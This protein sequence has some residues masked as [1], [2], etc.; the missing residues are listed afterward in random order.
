MKI[1]ICLLACSCTMQKPV[2]T[3]VAEITEVHRCWSTLPGKTSIAST[4]C[5][6]MTKGNL[7]PTQVKKCDAIPGNFIC[8]KT[9]KE[10][11]R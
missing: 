11:K 3:K 9:A 2:C 1:A 6:V 7:T 8:L 10:R 5:S 4:V